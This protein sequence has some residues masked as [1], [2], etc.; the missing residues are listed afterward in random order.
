QQK[1]KMLPPFLYLL[2]LLLPNLCTPH[3]CYPPPMLLPL[4]P[5][6]LALI[7]SIDAFSRFSPRYKRW[8]RH[9]PASTLTEP[10]PK[11][12]FL[13]K[14]DY[15]A[16]GGGGTT[17]SPPRRSTSTGTGTGTCVLVVDVAAGAGAGAGVDPST[18]VDS[19]GLVDVAR[20]AREVY[21]RCLLGRGQ[22][23]LEFPSEEGHVYVKVA[24]LDGRPPGGVGAGRRRTAGR[25]RLEGGK[26]WLRI[27][28]G[29]AVSAAAAAS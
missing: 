14:E 27:E 16:G 15:G 28:G 13:E 22:V 7:A 9:L 2:L 11:Y 4:P 23:G 24:R 3:I 1:T 26:G 12:Y 25:V 21:A 17:Q 10:L 18:A 20:A 19:F 5:D 29:R 8:G 6:C